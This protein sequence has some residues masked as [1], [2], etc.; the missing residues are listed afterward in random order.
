[1]CFMRSEKQI[2]TWNFPIIPTITPPTEEDQNNNHWESR[3]SY[4]D[5]IDDVIRYAEREIDQLEYERDQL[6][7]RVQDL[8]DENEKQMLELV[9]DY[10]KLADSY[11]RAYQK[12]HQIVKSEINHEWFSSS[13]EEMVHP[14]ELD[15]LTG[16]FIAGIA[17][18]V[19]FFIL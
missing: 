5:D 8:E 2:L 9:D 11:D 4:S 15:D 13:S 1:M 18:A 3:F 14:K 19:I 16:M 12:A 17:I 7:R 6:K 10:K